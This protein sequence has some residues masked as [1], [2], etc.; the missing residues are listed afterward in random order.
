MYLFFDTETTGLPKN[1]KASVENTD[2]WPR[3]IQIAWML[4]DKTGKKLDSKDF[5][6]KPKG[7]VIPA[8]STKIHGI[9]TEIAKEKGNDLR[10]VLALFGDYI[11]RSSILV[12]HN[13]KFD[14]MIVGAEFIRENMESKL[15]RK[16]RVCTMVGSRDYCNITGPYGL[17]WPT[18]SELHIKLFGEDF[19]NAHDAYSDISATARCFWELKEL[20]VL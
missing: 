17:K 6:I 18:L 19:Q 15:F 9:T 14:E 2:N 10:Y 5:I 8:E 11:N 12:A 20:N 4:Y 7:F 16:E 1:W 3:M 13:I